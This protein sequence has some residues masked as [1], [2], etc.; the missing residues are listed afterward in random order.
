MH[1]STFD[2]NDIIFIC[3]SIKSFMYELIFMFIQTLIR[4]RFNLFWFRSFNKSQSIIQRIYLLFIMNISTF[5][6]EEIN[7]PFISIDNFETYLVCFMNQKFIIKN[8]LLIYV[9]KKNRNLFLNK[10]RRRRW[11]FW[12]SI[13]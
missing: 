5:V 10:Y 8:E 12:K 11:K 6:H 9:L 3:A 1:E 13:E 7:D 4:S 2:I